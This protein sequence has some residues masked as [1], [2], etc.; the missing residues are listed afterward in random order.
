MAGQIAE[1]AHHTLV[2]EFRSIDPRR[3]RVILLDA[4]H[5]V[6]P[7]F[8]A[9]L[10][11]KAQAA[12][13]KRG[14]EV[15][16]DEMVVD[17]DER[18]LVVKDPA[19]NTERIEAITKVWAAGV[20]ANNLGAMLAEQS[21]AELDRAGRVK[22]NSDLTLPG[23]PEVFVV[24]DMMS[25][26][27]LPGVAQV[28]IQGAKYAGKEIN[29]RLTGRAPQTA[30]KYV[31]KGSMATISKHQAVALVGRLRLTGFL[32]WVLWCALHL[33]YLTGFKNRFTTLV[34]WVVTFSS[35][36]RAERVSTVQQ[37]FAR[38]ALAQLE[39]GASEFVSR[40]GDWRRTQAELAARAEEE[41]RLTD[42]RK[43]GTKG[44]EQ[45]SAS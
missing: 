30:F 12:L 24:G 31:D 15:R 11:Q 19:G 6:L 3:A 40:P 29:N 8:G 32:A 4:A 2:G 13:E 14:V 43:R 22:V 10:G 42:Q 34:H 26:N 1:L 36:G 16:L 5:Q 37:V 33:V 45:I 44:A 18:S 25:L 41:A 39:R 20:Q 21:G 27:E 35:H 23:H 28:A 17:I 9:K 38:R 7:P